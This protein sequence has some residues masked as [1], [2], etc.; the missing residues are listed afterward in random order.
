[1]GKRSEQSLY[2]GRS[3]NGQ[4]SHEEILTI[5][6]YKRNANQITLRFYL[7]LVKMATIMN[8]SNNK[9]WQG[10]GEKG[11]LIHCWWECNLVQ[12][13]WKK[14][15]RLLKKSKHRSAI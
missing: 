5:P 4:K 12:P 13:L 15:W 10:C 1:M 14:I 6:D 11:N 3:P 9:C 2:K 7:T 8:I